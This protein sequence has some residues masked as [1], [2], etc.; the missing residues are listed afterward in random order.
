MEEA[1]D[2]RRIIGDPKGASDDLADSFACPDLPAKPVCFRPTIQERRHL[3]E[4]VRRELGGG[5]RG[6]MTTQS[7]LNPFD[8]RS[9]EPLTHRS[10]RHPK[11]S[12]DVLLFPVRLFE[13][14][15]ASP[16]SFAPVQP[17]Y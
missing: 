1:A 5:A 8:M 4:L 7:F 10:R 14:P 17:G 13:L 2:V 6:R 12:R 11:G 9:P 3:G 15:G 16:P